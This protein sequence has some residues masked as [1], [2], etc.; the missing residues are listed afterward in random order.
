MHLLAVA[1]GQGRLKASD[2][3]GDVLTAPDRQALLTWLRYRPLLHHD[4]ALGMTLVH[5]GLP[6]QWTLD[7]A[8]AYAAEV[9]A[10]LRGPDYGALLAR[11]GTKTPGPGPPCA[12]AGSA[13]VT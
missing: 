6:P 3:F 7:M 8:Q 4:A 13:S 11:L 10:M 12:T 1:S 5:A 9:E 2:T